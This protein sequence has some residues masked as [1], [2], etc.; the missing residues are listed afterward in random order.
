MAFSQVYSEGGAMKTGTICVLTMAMALISAGGMAVADTV[1]RIG[2]VGD[3][4]REF[5]MAGRYQEYPSRFQNDAVF[6][7]GRDKTGDTW[8]YIH[9]GPMDVWAGSKSHTFTIQFDLATEPKGVYRFSVH[10]ASANNNP[11]VPLMQVKVNETAPY[12]LV[13]D[14]GPEDK[15]LI[16]PSAG[17]RQT[18]SFLLRASCLRKGH[19]VITLTS[20]EG[21][22][23]L[24]DA[25]TFETTEVKG[26]DPDTIQ[27]FT[28]PLFKRFGSD[29]KQVVRVVMHNNG[30]DGEAILAIKELPDTKQQIQLAQ[31]TTTVDLFV[32]PFE[33]PTPQ[34]VVLLAKEKTLET[35]FEGRPARHWKIYVT[36]STHTDIGYTDFQEKVF[37]KHRENTAT[38]VKTCETNPDFKWNFETFEQATWTLWHGSATSATLERLI[39]ERRIGLMSFS[40]NMLTGICSGDEMIKVLTPAQRYGRLHNAPV[41]MAT[42]ND[43]PTTVGTLPMLLKQAGV[44][45]FAEGINN[46]D[47]GPVWMHADK[48]MIQ[49][50]FWWEGLDGSRVMAVF[51][52][53]YAQGH[54]LGLRDNIEAMKQKLPGWLEVVDRPDYPGDAVY[55]NGVYWDNEVVSPHFFD[56]AAEWNKTWAFPQIILSRGEEFFQYV[57]QNFGSAL[58]VYRGDMGSYWE[59]GAASSALET[60]MVRLAK[61]R[62]NV[63]SRREALAAA[64]DPNWAFPKEAFSKAWN[65]AIYYDEHTWGAAGSVEDPYGENTLKQW[66][67]KAAY[68]QRAAQAADELDGNTRSSLKLLA[69]PNLDKD[70]YVT[71]WNDCSW[72][73]DITVA[74]PDAGNN[75]MVQTSG[76]KTIPS[77][78]QDTTTFFRATD[79]PAMGYRC[80][81]LKPEKATKAQEGLLR[82]C[83]DAYT[84]ESPNYRFRLDPKTGAFSSIEDLKTHREWVDGSEGY[85]LNQFLYVTGGKGTSLAKPYEKPV[86]PLQPVSHTEATVRLT[87]NT[88]ICA[89]LHVSRSGGGASSIETDY[90]IH[91]DGRL[92]ILNTINKQET[93]EKEAGYFAFPFKLNTSEHTKSFFDIPYGIVEADKEQMPGACRAWY[94]VNSFMAVSDD[95]TSAYVATREAPLFTIGTMVDGTWPGKLAKNHGTV[96]AYVFNNYWYTNYKGVQG[97]PLTFSFSLKLNESTFDPVTATR[98]GWETLTSDTTQ[99]MLCSNVKSGYSTSFKTNNFLN[100]GDGS[101]LLTE[102]TYDDQKRLVTRFYNPSSSEATTTLTFPQLTIEKAWKTDLC[103]DHGE[104]AQIIKGVLHVYVAPRS[105]ATYVIQTAPQP[106]RKMAPMTNAQLLHMSRQYIHHKLG[107]AYEMDGVVERRIINADQLPL[108]FSMLKDPNFKDSWYQIAKRI[109][110]MSNHANHQS[111]DA[112][113]DYVRRPEDWT[114]VEK[115]SP[116]SFSLGMGKFMGLEFIGMIGGNNAKRI[117]RKVL[118]RE[119]ATELIEAWRPETV[120]AVAGSLEQALVCIQSRTA[121]GLVY[122][123]DAKGIKEVERLYQEEC[124]RCKSQGLFTNESLNGLI[125]ALGARDYIADFGLEKRIVESFSDQIGDI[126]LYFEKYH[127]KAQ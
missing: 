87:M 30:L 85:G 120:T 104:L 7:I 19:N 15:V 50:P 11:R 77:F 54:V 37:E 84:F 5:A 111:I 100:I 27:A 65:D 2:N 114:N 14:R 126:G 113:L 64:H 22:W 101:I 57:E 32:P 90:A 4:Y 81:K 51:T 106:V 89:V 45:Y 92:D 66:A 24:Y 78:Q 16:D 97:G 20:T 39:A 25:L 34:Q 43:I 116:T 63:A 102:L 103:G 6:Q 99:G 73:R 53:S 29:L 52:R 96:F 12:T 60:G 71:V 74:V 3:S 36:P 75:V 68:A 80:Y 44:K 49:S 26:I 62:L 13:F 46:N 47:R 123:G 8:P 48:Q 95:V 67:Y 61:A 93:T 127:L 76:H 88:P 125:S 82:P 107:P 69:P 72:D 109:T 83:S 91:A 55:A 112:I 21:S 33:K 58:P 23:I 41:T 17:R 118:T 40:L 115:D 108:L 70:H 35:A 121:M 18:Q 86:P 94:A 110:L 1:W 105:I 119:G 42:I 56:V 28:T 79:V 31:G 117:L 10:A 38:V 98:F 9:P 122:C 59:D 124:R